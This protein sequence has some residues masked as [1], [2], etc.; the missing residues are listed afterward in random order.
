MNKEQGKEIP[1]RFILNNVPSGFKLVIKD[2]ETETIL[3]NS[4]EILLLILNK[5]DK[6]ERTLA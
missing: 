6:I 3:E 5:I 4:D 1:D 2:N